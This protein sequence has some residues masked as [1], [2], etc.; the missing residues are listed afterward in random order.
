MDPILD[1]GVAGYYTG[2]VGT[3]LD[4]SGFGGTLVDLAK[5]WGTVEVAN[6]KAAQPI[7]SRAPNGQLY[8]EGVPVGTLP[9]GTGGGGLS[10]LLLLL[11][12]GGAIFAL[13]D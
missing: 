5:V 11:L 8:R 2:D 3:G 13:K 10:P 1:N 12:I 4:W 7:Y 9:G 6:T